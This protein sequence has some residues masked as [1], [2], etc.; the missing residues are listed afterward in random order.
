MVM[1]NLKMLKNNMEKKLVLNRWA[2]PDGTVLTS[3]STHDYIQH[4]DK[5]GDTY[6]I[7]GGSDYIRMSVNDVPMTNM[8]VYDDAPF[9]VIRKSVYRGTFDNESRRVWIPLCNMSNPHLENCITYY[10][11]SFSDNGCANR[12]V[13]FYILEL[14]YRWRSGVYVAEKH[15]TKDDNV[16]NANELNVTKTITDDLNTGMLETIDDFSDSIS[17]GVHSDDESVVKMLQHILNIWKENDIELKQK[18]ENY[19]AGIN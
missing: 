10:V 16:A 13:A 8:C 11:R 2:T 9:S 14:L 17:D 1:L 5:N 6:F 3:Y 19:E 18:I 4:T 12:Y 7:D 15:Y